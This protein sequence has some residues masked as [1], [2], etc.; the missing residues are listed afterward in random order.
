M[1]THMLSVRSRNGYHSGME[2]LPELQR[3]SCRHRLLSPGTPL[4]KAWP[5]TGRTP[6]P[7]LLD[8][9]G[10]VIATVVLDQDERGTRARHWRRSM[11]S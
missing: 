5:G 4:C 7:A 10:A 8:G 3:P 1:K 2:A 11:P 9:S 6:G